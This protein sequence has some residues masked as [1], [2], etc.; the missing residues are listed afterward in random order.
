[1]FPFL[2][3]LGKAIQIINAAERSLLRWRLPGWAPP[4]PQ[5]G[6]FWGG[7]KKKVKPPGGRWQFTQAINIVQRADRTSQAS[8]LQ[9]SERGTQVT[10]SASELDT[11]CITPP[12]SC[13]GQPW[14]VAVTGII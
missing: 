5:S 13:I 3:L 6:I 12:G 8:Q 2:L 7:K 4:T 14:G 9:T 11:E 1:M 10:V